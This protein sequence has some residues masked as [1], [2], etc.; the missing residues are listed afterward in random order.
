MSTN[1]QEEKYILIKLSDAKLIA[2][3]IRKEIIEKESP[4]RYVYTDI[5]R[6]IA[7]L[8]TILERFEKEEGADIV[9]IVKR[10]KGLSYCHAC[11][12][13]G[14]QHSCVSPYANK[15]GRRL[16]RL[17]DRA[18]G[19]IP[20]GNQEIPKEQES[21]KESEE[22]EVK[23][24]PVTQSPVIS[25]IDS[26]RQRMCGKNA[27]NLVNDFLKEQEGVGLTM[28]N[29]YNIIKGITDLLDGWRTAYRGKWFYANG[30]P[31]YGE[32][33]LF[34]VTFDRS[35]IHCDA[36]PELIRLINGNSNIVFNS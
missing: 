24:E 21:P 23:K 6:Q 2:Q 14:Q 17:V 30:L 12:V 29:R 28:Q 15:I 31:C 20:P 18:N 26:A 19:I 5:V 1:N 33:F 11:V 25:E 7:P 3:L 35:V 22:K 27:L 13:E 16:K 4:Y 8:E 34:Y 10:L 9:D 32:K 36:S